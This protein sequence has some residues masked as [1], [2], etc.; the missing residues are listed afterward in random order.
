M[1]LLRR[2]PKVDGSDSDFQAFA[3]LSLANDSNLLLE[4]LICLQPRSTFEPWH[5][6]SD[7]W[8]AKLW[9]IYPT[10]QVSAIAED[11][12][13]ILD[14]AFGAAIRWKSFTP[15]AS[16]VRDGWRRFFAKIF[17][18]SSPTVLVIASVVLGLRLQYGPA[19]TAIGLILLLIALV[20]LLLSPYLVR[21]LYS[22][23]LWFTQ[24]WFFGF[25]G[26]LPLEQIEARI[27]GIHSPSQTRLTWSATGSPLSRHESVDGE[28]IGIDPT[29]DP[30]IAN[31]VR[32]AVHAPYG[33]ERVFTL[34][35]TY[36]MTVTLFQAVRPP[37]AVVLCGSEG[38]MQRAV[39]CSYEWKKGILWKEAVLRMETTVLEKLS[40]VA[41]FRI[42]LKREH[43]K[44]MR[45]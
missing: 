31:I 8:G 37:V 23:K 9:D 4:R 42:G 32:K 7:A 35:D 40:R 6:M 43:V 29:R 30:E 28:C 13:V 39:L 36:T 41:R 22:G 14:G 44:V 26:Y 17:L 21:V 18:R 45:R 3:R 20:Q 24:P 1:G 11:N 15:V 38:G 12:T 10:C 25:E 16:L 34:V 33:Q 27:F 5:T 2:R 19:A